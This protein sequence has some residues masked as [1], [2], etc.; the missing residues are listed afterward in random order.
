MGFRGCS[1]HS[2]RTQIKSRSAAAPL[3]LSSLQSPHTSARR[4]CRLAQL[5]SNQRDNT[6]KASVQ[7]SA[8]T[9]S[10]SPV[11]TPDQASFILSTVSEIDK[12]GDEARSDRVSGQPISSASSRSSDVSSGSQYWQ[13]LLSSPEPEMFGHRA[14]SASDAAVLRRKGHLKEQDK[15]I[16][17]LLAM[18]HTHTSEEVMQKME[19]WIMEHR[20]EPRHSRL[21]K[22]VPS[23]GSFFTPLK[24]VEAFSEFDQFFALSRRKY[25][26]PNFAEIR[27][28]LNIAQ[29]SL[30]LPEKLQCCTHECWHINTTSFTAC[31]QTL[32]TCIQA[33]H[34]SLTWHLCMQLSS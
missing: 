21:R 26:A 4:P 22:M 34:D 12:D 32:V 29:V 14:K 2:G 20:Q 33:S 13:E 11:T 18:H 9:A 5:C 25:V 1:L 7:A 3:W 31:L 23:I 15:M 17:F 27:H 8:A 28:I 30:V 24:L 6:H 16:E 10:P 19:R